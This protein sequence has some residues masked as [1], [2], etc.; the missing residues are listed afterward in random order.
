MNFLASSAPDFGNPGPILSVAGGSDH[1]L[2]SLLFQRIVNV[3]GGIDI[4]S[5]A[6]SRIK[7]V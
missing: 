5:V 7:Y 1:A 2:L 3:D 4:V 6:S